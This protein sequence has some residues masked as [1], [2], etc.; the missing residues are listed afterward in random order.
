MTQPLTRGQQVMSVSFNPGQREDVTA[1]KQAF[2]DA[3]DLIESAV[4]KQESKLG[5][6]PNMSTLQE[7]DE[8][9]GIRSDRWRL[10]TIAK[11]HL[12]TAQMYA[13]KAIT[14]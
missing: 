3:Y 9:Q 11:S 8:W 7:R 1:I 6:L 2:A 4:E 5:P 13:V 10:S 12:E 14:R